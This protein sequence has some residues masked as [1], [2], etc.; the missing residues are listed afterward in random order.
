MIVTCKNVLLAPNQ[1]FFRNSI[2]NR[3]MLHLFSE[4]QF[5]KLHLFV[6]EIHKTPNVDTQTIWMTRRFFTPLRCMKSSDS[7]I[8][9]DLGNSSDDAC[10][11]DK[12]NNHHRS[13]QETPEKNF[14]GAVGLI[15]GTAVGPGML[16][17][18]ALTVR[19]GPLPSSISIVFSWF[20][21]ISSIVLVAEL[22]YAVMEEDGVA[23]V[24]F[25]G[26]AKKTLGDQF[27]SFV[28]LV[29]ASLSFS[30]L[31]ASV[32]GI[33]SIVAQWL[34]GLNSFIANA[35]FPLVVGS[36]LWLFPFTA[37]DFFNRFLC[38][39]MLLSMTALVVIGS[40]VA[41]TQIFDSFSYASWSIA[42]VLPTVPVTVLTLGFHVITPFV[43]KIAGGTL[44]EARRAILI[45]GMIPLIM[46]LT[47][48]LII[49]GLTGT[50]NGTPV[51]DPI[52]LLLSVSSALLA[53][54]GFAFSALATS[55]IGYAVSFPKQVIDTIELI[56]DETNSRRKNVPN[57]YHLPTSVLRSEKGKVGLI[58]FTNGRSHGKIGTFFCSRLSYKCLDQ[59]VLVPKSN[60]FR[61][62]VMPVVLGLPVAI[63]CL[64]SS[65]FTKA[66]DFAGIYANCFL[67]GILPPVMVH[68]YQRKKGHRFISLPGGDAALLLLFSISVVLAIWH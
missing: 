63:A 57:I 68:I 62:S 58:T 10:A 50:T 12:L 43:C 5:K 49:L 46:V 60:F 3:S 21:V 35:L 37:I 40:L 47:W 54:Q 41:R 26:L 15:L 65:S 64:F 42:S 20:Y 33:G 13:Y 19:S 56:F 52:S 30:L 36:V 38:I 59:L 28:S 16:G 53:V 48:N 24:S 23:E 44:H 17:L 67:F 22:S 34:P 29:Y 1:T 9:F 4:G 45:G 61:R 14:W 39:L 32:S 27:G 18:P 7:S 51:T 66:L 11:L 31:V 6:S 2:L 8:G 55:L 25:T